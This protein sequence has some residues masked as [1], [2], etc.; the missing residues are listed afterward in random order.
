[1]TTSGGDFHLRALG[2]QLWEI[3]NG[4]RQIPD[5]QIEDRFRTDDS[6]VEVIKR[7]EFALLICQ[8]G[9]REGLSID[10]LEGNV[11]CEGFFCVVGDG[12]RTS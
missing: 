1:M 3:E 11:R 12:V 8:Q 10:G 9:Q 4:Y 7:L 5:H 2:P 6:M